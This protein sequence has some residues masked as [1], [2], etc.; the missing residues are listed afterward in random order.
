METVSERE[1]GLFRNSL[2][3]N[4]MVCAQGTL[5][6][7][8]G[9]VGRRREGRYCRCVKE[10]HPV[11]LCSGL[12]IACLHICMLVREPSGRALSR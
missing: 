10:V 1:L 11:K 5:A 3:G 2:C 12:S 8:S 6:G 7:Q 4:T 9:R